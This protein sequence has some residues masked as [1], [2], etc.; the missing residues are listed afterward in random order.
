MKVNSLEVLVNS[1]KPQLVLAKETV[2]RIANDNYVKDQILGD[3][4]AQLLYLWI[5][6]YK[7]LA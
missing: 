3:N 2:E 7:N 6:D 5:L 1:R 4:I